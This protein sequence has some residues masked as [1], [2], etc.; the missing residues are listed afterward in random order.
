MFFPVWPA[1]VLF[2]VFRKR[3]YSGEVFLVFLFGQW[4]FRIF[5]VDL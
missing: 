4:L 2:F 3:A 5:F 1:F